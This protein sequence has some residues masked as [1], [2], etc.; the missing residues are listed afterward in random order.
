MRP[1]RGRRLRS[2]GSKEQAWRLLQELLPATK[3]MVVS[4]GLP[5][6]YAGGLFNTACLVADGKILG[7]VAKQ[8]LA[9]EGIH[10]EPRWFKP[11]PS[12]VRAEIEIADVR[13]PLGDLLFDVGGV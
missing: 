8:N 1:M 9:G 12:G 4:F 2:R 6:L 13:Y 5:L 3:G 11:W 10:Y 7:F